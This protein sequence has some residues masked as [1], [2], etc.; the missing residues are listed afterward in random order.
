MGGKQHMERCA[1][2]R[3]AALTIFDLRSGGEPKSR[4]LHLLP[5]SSPAGDERSA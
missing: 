1:S 3:A 2:G 4:A 5:S